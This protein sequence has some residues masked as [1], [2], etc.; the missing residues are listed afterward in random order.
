MSDLDVGQILDRTVQPL[1]GDDEARGAGETA[2]LNA[3]ASRRNA[4]DI[5]VCAGRGRLEPDHPPRV[6]RVLRR[7]VVV[8]EAPGG[9]DEAKAESNLVRVAAGGHPQ[10]L[11]SVPV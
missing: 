4:A 7:R 8:V 9:A 3:H 5:D 2:L 11:V 10:L 6:E 1:G